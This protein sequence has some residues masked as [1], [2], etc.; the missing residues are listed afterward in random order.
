MHVCRRTVNKFS[1]LEK[2]TL[3]FFHQLRQ[4]VKKKDRRHFSVECTVYL[5]LS[6]TKYIT[7]SQKDKM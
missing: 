5:T 2:K 7:H 4:N 3:P 1:S 6:H